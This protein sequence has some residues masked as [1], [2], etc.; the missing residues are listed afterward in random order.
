M[1]TA[2]GVRGSIKSQLDTNAPG[3]RAHRLPVS[4]K[5]TWFIITKTVLIFLG[6]F[7]WNVL[8]YTGLVVVRM[9]SQGNDS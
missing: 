3:H 6:K 7:Y 8:N 1:G 5:P 2:N 9:H 4:D